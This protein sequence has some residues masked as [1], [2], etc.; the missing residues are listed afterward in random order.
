MS[1]FFG[2]YRTY[3]SGT[4]LN[5]GG[6]GDIY[7]VD[8][9]HVAKIYNDTVDKPE[10]ERKLK[11]MMKIKLPRELI[12]SVAWPEDVIYD[13]R[14]NFVGFIMRR[15]S[16]KYL[17]AELTAYP[18]S[19]IR[20]HEMG[21]RAFWLIAWNLVYIFV[22]LHEI[23]I[24]V[25]DVNEENIGF[26]EDGS[27][28][29]YDCDSF[30]ISD[31]HRCVVARPEY[32]P[33]FL[34][35][36]LS[37][38][39]DKYAG[40]TFSEVSDDW[41]L[42]AHIFELIC[43]GCHPFSCA[44]SSSTSRIPNIPENIRY[45]NCPFFVGMKGF[46]PPKYAPSLGIIPERMR[47]MFEKAFI[48]D[49]T[50]IPS[51]KEWLNE[52]GVVLAAPFDCICSQKHHVLPAEFI[53]SGDTNCPLCKARLMSSKVI[54]PDNEFE[55]YLVRGKPINI[56]PTK[57][58]VN[59]HQHNN[60]KRKLGLFK[61]IKQSKLWGK[62]SSFANKLYKG[63]WMAM[64]FINGSILGILSLTYFTS[65]QMS[66]DPAFQAIMLARI[67]M[68]ILPIISSLHGNRMA[69]IGV[70]LSLLAID[71]FLPDAVLSQPLGYAVHGVLFALSAICLIGKVKP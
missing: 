23:N 57:P 53:A 61:R 52:L 29:I 69:G 66:G 13:Q 33:Y 9:T 60:A 26:K 24:V 27:P 65:P 21:Y 20:P 42:A 71:F 41:A 63:S 35:D 12:D 46:R 70:S 15:I 2:R 28:V 45:R 47:T 19:D 11:Q 68:M 6:E 50:E 64:A 31:E 32:V 17:L 14:G 43:N 67:S 39:F 8:G 59:R 7:E 18:R 38:G 1:L 58:I 10:R 56:T 30:H 4:F 37:E 48:G 40:Q 49:Q 5:S 3:A 62:L 25:G 22:R 36:A 51:A 55:N 44:R 54:P 34:F 16:S